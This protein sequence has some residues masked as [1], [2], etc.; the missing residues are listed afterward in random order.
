MSRTSS[1]AASLSGMNS[2]VPA[3]VAGMGMFVAAASKL[4][5]TA[6]SCASVS[7]SLRAFKQ[8]DRVRRCFLG[9][10]AFDA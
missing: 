1:E 5:A 7:A 2:A 10:S 3:D 6:S 9:P 8:P 4:S